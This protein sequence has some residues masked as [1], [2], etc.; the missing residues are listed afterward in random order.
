MKTVDE[1]LTDLR[2]SFH[3]DPEVG[4]SE[5][6]TKAKV[7]QQLRAFGVEMHEG[8]GVVGV[9]RSG[10]GNR[11][12]G[13]RVDM[14]ALPIWKSSFHDYISKNDGVMHACGHDGHM[15]MLLGAAEILANEPD[16][17]SKVVIIFQP[18]EEHGLG[19]RA[20]IDG[21]LLD[22]FPLDEVYAIHS[23]PGAPLGELFTRV[24]QICT[25]ESLF[26]IE[27]RGQG[28]HASMP[29]VGVEA[30]TVRAEIVQ[31]LQTIVSRKLAPRCG[32]VVSATEFLTNGQRN[33]LPETARL[34]GDVRTRLAQDRQDVECFMRQIVDGIAAAHG[35][36]ATVA[37]NTGSIET[38]DAPG[39]TEAMIQASRNAGLDT[40][41]DRPPMSCSEDFAHFCAAV[42]ECFLLLGN[43]TERPY[44]QPLH[45]S[46]C[47]FNDALLPIGAVFLAQLV[48]DRLPKKRAT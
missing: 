39:P 7:A 4:F 29:H 42:P 43:G 19:A 33:V 38:I 25:S 1:K 41:P 45:A 24:G 37:F 23:L 14:D 8:I 20:M 22:R 31:A 17:D 34:N 5:V 16:F 27:I 30:I 12:I 32:A 28:G 9:L 2:R 48:R 11:T 3:R 10:G 15:T 46:D 13:L 35:V 26:D 18:N 44:I 6:R 47:D 21:G 36:G 40:I